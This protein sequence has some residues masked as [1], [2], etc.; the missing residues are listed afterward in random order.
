M[1]T[2]VSPLGE[3]RVIVSRRT[4]LRR[5]LSRGGRRWTPLEYQ[6]LVELFERDVW[7]RTLGWAGASRLKAEYGPQTFLVALERLA[8]G[9]RTNLGPTHNAY[10]YLRAICRAVQREY[11]R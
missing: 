7:R 5:R 2:Y 10:A 9:L 3:D 1:D 11:Q 6:L 8:E 4:R